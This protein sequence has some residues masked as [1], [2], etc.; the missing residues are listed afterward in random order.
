MYE[1]GSCETITFPHICGAT[2][3]TLFKLLDAG[4]VAHRRPRGPQHVIVTSVRNTTVD[5]YSKFLGQPSIMRGQYLE[6]GY[7]TY[8]R[9]PSRFIM[10]HHN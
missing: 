10:L 3:V 8:P 2:C 5:V 9:F 7:S 6:T 1:F 4:T